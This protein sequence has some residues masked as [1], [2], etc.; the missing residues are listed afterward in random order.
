M[1]ILS[2]L[3]NKFFWFY[4]ST[5]SQIEHIERIENQLIKAMCPMSLCVKLNQK[6]LWFDY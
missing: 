3:T 1:K 4:Y 6:T 5:H 2:T